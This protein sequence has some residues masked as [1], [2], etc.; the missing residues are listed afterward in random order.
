MLFLHRS[1][2]YEGDPQAAPTG[3]LAL[4]FQLPVFRY[5]FGESREGVYVIQV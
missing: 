2:T 3:P 5:A 4:T 1:F